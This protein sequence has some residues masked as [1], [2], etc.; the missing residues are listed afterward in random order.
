MT[1]S[2]RCI[3]IQHGSHVLFCTTE[4]GLIRAETS[5]EFGTVY[6]VFIRLRIALLAV[7]MKHA[8]S[9]T[10]CPANTTDQPQPHAVF[11]SSSQKWLY[12][13]MTIISYIIQ[14]HITLTVDYGD[15]STAPEEVGLS[16]ARAP[17]CSVPEEL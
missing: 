2:Y 10:P 13:I 1:S 9:Q 11:V 7:I 16:T 14:L 6:H 8:V 5:C 12:N 4:E 3:N 15:V 17:L